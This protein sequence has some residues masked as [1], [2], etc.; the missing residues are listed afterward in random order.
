MEPKWSRD[1][2]ELYYIAYDGKLMAL[3]VKGDRVL[4]VGTPEP[5]FETPITVNRAQLDGTRRYDVGPDGRFLF[6]VPLRTENSNPPVA[7]VNWATL[8]DKK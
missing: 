7:F 4:E 3:P 5:L 1:G 2:H 6:A 8:L